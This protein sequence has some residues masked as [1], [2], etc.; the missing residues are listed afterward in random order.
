MLWRLSLSAKN[1][2]VHPPPSVLISQYTLYGP[3]P[4]APSGSICCGPLAAPG[5]WPRTSLHEVG[6]KVPT[7]V[8]AASLAVASA[9][10]AVLLSTAQAAKATT[11]TKFRMR[12]C[13]TMSGI[14]AERL[15]ACKR[16]ERWPSAK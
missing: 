5:E 11:P 9:A 7:S 1:T 6:T 4:A 12:A 13:P 16:R 3:V 15:R 10:T 2:T 8:L 14:V